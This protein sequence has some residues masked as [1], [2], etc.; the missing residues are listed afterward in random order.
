MIEKIIDLVTENWFWVLLF[1]G[2]IYGFLTNLAEKIS[3]FYIGWRSE[4]R[5]AKERFMKEKPKLPDAP[6]MPPREDLFT[7][8]KAKWTFK[9]AREEFGDRI[10]ERV[11][12]RMMENVDNSA[13]FSLTN[14]LHE[15]EK[16]EY[17]QTRDYEKGYTKTDWKYP[18]KHDG[19]IGEDPEKVINTFELKEGDVSF[20]T[21]KEW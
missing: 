8:K 5:K 7:K 15:C 6:I 21:L 3:D 19:R 12:Y 13:D 1:G 10:A 17:K 2:S 16:E 4:R 9:S 14:F 11:F 18:S 20:K